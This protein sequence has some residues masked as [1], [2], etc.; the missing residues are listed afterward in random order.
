MNRIVGRMSVLLMLSA[1]GCGGGGSGNDMTA[2]DPMGNC[3]SMSCGMPSMS[4]MNSA[5]RPQEPFALPPTTL[6]ASANGNSYRLTYSL[7]ANSGT[8]MFDGQMANSA[9]IVLTVLENGT[10]VATE[11]ATAYYLTSPYTPLGLAGTVNG[12]AFEIIFSSIDPY[13]ATFTVGD[14]GPLASGTFYAAGTNTALGSLTITYSV[15]ANNSSTLLLKVSSSATLAGNPLPDVI[16]YAVDASGHT[17]LSSVEVTLNGM[18][19][20]FR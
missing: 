6:T 16:A 17:T 19:L 1:A 8:T 5:P 18:T 14:S 15:E 11:N 2:A 13:P 10:T 12:T 20:M 9:S 7:T 4:H 3:M